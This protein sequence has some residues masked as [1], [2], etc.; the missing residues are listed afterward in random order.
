MKTEEF[1]NKEIIVIYPGRFQPFHKGHLKIYNWLKSKF[2]N[3]FITT[4]NT[5]ELD[6]SPFSFDEKR[7]I[8]L[9]SG[10]GENS[11]IQAS[12]PY[13]PDELLENYDPTKTILVMAVSQKD[14]S[15]E[16]PRFSFNDKKDGSKSY[17]Q[18]FDTNNM[19]PMDKHGYVIV[20]PTVEFSILGKSVNSATEIRDMFKNSTP[21][22]QRKIVKDLYGKYSDEIHELLRKKLNILTSSFVNE[23][24]EYHLTTKTPIRESIL[25]SGSRSFFDMI[26]HIKE[27][28]SNYYLDEIDRELLK[29]DIGEIV[30][31]KD[32]TQV[33]LDLPFTRTD[34]EMM[35]AEYRGKDVTL[36]QPKRGGPKKFYVYVRDPKT[37]NIKKVN[38]GASGM[39]V[40]ANNPDRVKAFVSRHDCKNKNDKTKPSYW[41]CRLPRYKSLGIKGGQWW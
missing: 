10:V 41:S 31:L 11:I 13:S 8:M 22:I 16:N 20:V 9:F 39:S 28:I 7:K 1:E 19:Q 21:N 40:K 4:S 14:M 32:G 27:N 17:F 36:N 24:L 5:T 37:K 15:G 30:T 38:F 18:K 23:A 29:T 34:E 26:N 6:R 2:D 25:R 12:K 3:V 33:P 35:E